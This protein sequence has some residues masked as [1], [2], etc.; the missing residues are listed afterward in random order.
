MEGSSRDAGDVL[1]IVSEFDIIKILVRW[2]RW[3]VVSILPLFSLTC[4]GMVEHCMVSVNIVRIMWQKIVNDAT[5]QR[6]GQI[7]DM[8]RCW[9]V[10]TIFQ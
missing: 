3:I 6:L 2:I 7:I 5:Q 4:I 10:V 9:G 8:L 1:C